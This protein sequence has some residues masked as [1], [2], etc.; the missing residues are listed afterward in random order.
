MNKELKKLY[1]ILDGIEDKILEVRDEAE[2]YD[3]NEI[4]ELM[5]DALER[6]RKRCRFPTRSGISLSVCD[7]GD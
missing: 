2:I 1:D 4:Y 3:G 6:F 7:E 5:E